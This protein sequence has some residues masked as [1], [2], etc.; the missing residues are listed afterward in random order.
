MEEQ[1]VILT[2]GLASHQAELGSEEVEPACLELSTAFDKMNAADSVGPLPRMGLAGSGRV[3]GAVVSITTS[4]DTDTECGVRRKGNQWGIGEEAASLRSTY[5]G[6]TG[7][8]IKW[9]VNKGSS[10]I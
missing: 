7:P 10:L 6:E 1:D 4:T 8:I 2:K 9:Q 3:C 5:H